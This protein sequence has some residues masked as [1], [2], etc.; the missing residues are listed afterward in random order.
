MLPDVI[1]SID[2]IHRMFILKSD[3]IFFD[4]PFDQIYVSSV[5]EVIDGLTFLAD[6]VEV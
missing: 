6:A 4:D 3:W 2:I 1:I 5:D